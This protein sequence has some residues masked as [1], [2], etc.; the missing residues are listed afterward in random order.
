MMLWDGGMGGSDMVSVLFAIGL[1][2]R[3]V[4]TGVMQLLRYR[5]RPGPASAATSQPSPQQV[6]AWVHHVWR[7]QRQ[8][9][10]GPDPLIRGVPT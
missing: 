7:Q 5:G 10:P 6:T 9:L 2:W 1:F 8:C 4:I 3:L